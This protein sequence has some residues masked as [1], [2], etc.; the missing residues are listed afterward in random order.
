MF[1][2]DRKK[3][4]F[5]EEIRS[6]LELEEDERRAEG[7]SADEAR[8]TA[9]VVFGNS[10]TTQEQFNLRHKWLWLEYIRQDARQ[11][12][13]SLWRSPAFTTAAVLTLALGIGATTAIFTLIHAVLLKSLPVKAPEQLWRVGDNEQCCVEEGLPNFN[14]KPG[15]WSVFS[16]EQYREFRDHTPGFESL[17]AF[18]S[19]SSDRL[20][21]RREGSSHAAEPFYGELVSGNAFDTL[22]LTAYAGRLLNQSDDAKGVAPVGVISFQAWQQKFGKDPSVVGSS[23]EMNGQVVTIVGIAPPGFY[24]DQLSD[25]PPS[26]WLP[27]NAMTVL[28][29]ENAVVDRPEEHW[30]NLIGRAR[31]GANMAA[32]EAQLEV[33]LRQVLNS[34]ESKIA[35]AEQ[36]FIAKQ[37]VRLTPGGGGVQRMQGAYRNDL[38]LLFWI[39]GFVLLIAC[40]NLANLMLA[41]SMTQQQ[42]MSVRTAVGASSQRLVQR[43]VM[44]CVVIA[45]FGGVTGLLVAWGAVKLILRLALQHDPIAISASPS[46]AIL[47]FTFAVSTL[48]AALFSI[49]PSWMAVHADPIDALRGANRATGQHTMLAQ[50]ALVVTQ[51]AV[52]AMLLCAAGFLIVSL[53]NLH[54]Q[55]FGFAVNNRYVLQI[56]PE[57]SGYRPEQLDAL[58]RQL[59]QRLAELPGVTEVAYSLYTPLS[60]NNWSQPIT[61]DGEPAPPPGQKVSASWNR[62]SPRYFDALGTKVLEGRA[63][64]ESDNRSSHSVAIVNREFIRSILHGKRAIGLSFGDWLPGP[65]ST[66][67]IVGVVEDVQYWGPDQP[68]RPMYYL[69]SEQWATLAPGHPGAA[70]HGEMVASSH[71][72]GSIVLE[73]HGDEGTLDAEVRRALAD[74]NPNLMVLSLQKFGT[75]V[76]LAFSQQTMIAKLTLW[77]GGLALALAVIGI[78][79]VTAYSVAQ[80]SGE[81][82]IRMALGANRASVQRMVLASAF[83]QTGAGLLIGIPG[84][85]LIGRLMSSQLFGIS[86][87]DPAILSAAS[88]V[89]MLATL[90]AAAIPALKASQINPIRVLRGQ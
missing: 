63:F 71:Y 34:A 16:Y 81:I 20:A 7:M 88:V 74:V 49:A 25:S 73:T 57:T 64:S 55:K 79:G 9:R 24:G 13:R 61:V 32:V 30:L 41:R 58:Y 59:R 48:T 28:E 52:S 40:A 10:V 27:L 6:H 84:A 21:V 33:E 62:V 70:A 72:M 75:Q 68:M 12:A 37:Y 67:E 53:N 54:H 86:F 23:F 89:L 14:N 35:A 87:G 22:G 60:G 44:E 11:A 46:P 1:R 18:E 76:E 65:A 80:R 38:H 69:P 29:P 17:A 5:A 8:R 83:A 90:A 3:E 42:Q 2:N 36:P 31:S 43:A 4:D 78:Y 56:D 15:D 66:Y 51:A 50:K 26:F 39:S 82:G 77:F 19:S 45:A 47:G 85:T